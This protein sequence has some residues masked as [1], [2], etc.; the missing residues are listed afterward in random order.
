MATTFQSETL[1]IVEDV[2]RDV[3]APEAASVD[4]E[5]RWPEVSIRALQNA[6]LGGL[7]APTASGGLGLGLLAVAKSCE[8]LGKDCGSTAL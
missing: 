1:R 8:V 3:V 2:A 6:G 7:V 4:L 5:A